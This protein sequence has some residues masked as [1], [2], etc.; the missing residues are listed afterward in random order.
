MLPAPKCIRSLV[1]RVCK[2]VIWYLRS[3]LPDSHAHG[4]QTGFASM[5]DV[6][7]ALDSDDRSR[8]SVRYRLTLVNQSASQS[9]PD[10]SAMY[11]VTCLSETSALAEKTTSYR[12]TTPGPA[13]QPGRGSPLSREAMAL[14]PCGPG[15]PRATCVHAGLECSKKTL[16]ARRLMTTMATWPFWG[17]CLHPT[18]LESGRESSPD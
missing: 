7:V 2:V 13:P 5:V 15:S 1:D 17:D 9:V 14:Q 3:S 11:R 12:L 6:A 10:S 8:A 4:A 18:P 16:A